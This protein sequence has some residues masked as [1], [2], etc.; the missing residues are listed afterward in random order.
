[1]IVTKGTDGTSREYSV[2]VSDK[3]KTTLIGPDHSDVNSDVVVINQVAPTPQ[4]V[5]PGA[6]RTE[7]TYRQGAVSTEAGVPV[8][9]DIRV[10][11]ETSHTAGYTEEQVL[12]AVAR[13]CGFY[14]QG[15]QAAD[16]IVVGRR[17]A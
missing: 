3:S 9:R 12:E 6:R 2:L 4:K 14:A 15:T 7:L 1:M 8:R 13:A 11:I 16:I 5:Y 10:K 17:P